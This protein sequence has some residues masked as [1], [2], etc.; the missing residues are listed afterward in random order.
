[1]SIVFLGGFFLP[2]RSQS[3]ER[4]SKLYVQ[5]AADALQRNLVKGLAAALPEKLGVLNL[6]FIGSFPQAYRRFIYQG[7]GWSSFGG[8]QVYEP[9]FNN[10]R[11]LRVLAR[12]WHAF[13]GLLNFRKVDCIVIYSP[14]LPFMSA[15]IAYRL[16]K[17][18]TQLVLIVPDFIEY[19][20]GGDG[21]WRKMVVLFET[22]LFRR[23]VKKFDRF[24]LLTEAMA[25]KLGLSRDQYFVLEGML[26]PEGDVE[27]APLGPGQKRQV[28][29]TGTLDARYGILDLLEAFS[30]LDEEGVELVICGAGDAE[31]A[32]LAA[33]NANPNISFRGRVPQSEARQIQREAYILVNPRRP[34]GDYTKYSF[35]SKTLEYMGAGRPLIMHELPGVPEEYLPFMLTPS[36][37]DAR[38]LASCLQ[39]AL[40]MQPEELEAFGRAA[41]RFVQLNKSSPVQCAKLST[42]LMRR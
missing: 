20:G 16:F 22:T 11:F 36:T 14:Y 42:W 18:K 7:G 2:E 17:P 28:T 6:P 26:D 5:Y 25:E 32:V 31:G 13:F 37:T 9:T 34:E 8:A 19:M 15:A 1:M 35:P 30:M 33:A 10:A 4:D 41:G 29:Y 39:K 40:R 3:I 12:M 23:M 24:V 38:G 21:W 27:T